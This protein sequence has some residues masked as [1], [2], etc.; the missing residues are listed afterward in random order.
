MLLLVSLYTGGSIFSPSSYP[1]HN[2]VF[3]MYPQYLTNCK[4]FCFCRTGEILHSWI[5]DIKMS[6]S[7]K[8]SAPNISFNFLPKGCNVYHTHIKSWTVLGGWKE[9]YTENNRAGFNLDK[10]IRKEFCM[11]LCSSAGFRGCDCWSIEAASSNDSQIL[12]QMYSLDSMCSEW[13]EATLH[14]IFE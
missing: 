3:E 5:L 6:K 10:N 14:V 2:C 13:E 9:I 7:L 8:L 12:Q 4:T 11:K 1:V